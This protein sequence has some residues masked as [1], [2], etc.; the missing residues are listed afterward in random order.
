V[1]VVVP[2][3]LATWLVLGTS[4]FAQ[5]ALPTCEQLRTEQDYK[6]NAEALLN[7]TLRDS[8]ARE[9]RVAVERAEKAENGL[10]QAMKRAEKAEADLAKA[11]AAEKKD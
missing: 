9:L 3:L 10:A 8:C 5:Q 4:L 6:L 1:F 7:R 2:V 11:A